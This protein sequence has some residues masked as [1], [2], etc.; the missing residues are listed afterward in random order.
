MR[1]IDAWACIQRVGAG[2]Y[3]E[4]TWAWSSEFEKGEGKVS[5]EAFSVDD[6]GARLVIFLLA[7][8]HLLEG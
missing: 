1:Q 4:P 7:D 8:P 6:A 2:M 5:L 3:A